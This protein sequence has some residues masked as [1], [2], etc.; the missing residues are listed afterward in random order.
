MSKLDDNLSPL[1]DEYGEVKAELVKLEKRKKEIVAFL[2]D[3]GIHELEG[4]LFRVVVSQVPESTGPDWKTI[5]AKLKPSRQLVRA[6]Q[7][8]TR[9]GH[10]RVSVY[11]R[12]GEVT[13]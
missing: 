1:A 9:K 3:A 7:I 11:G 5:A 13:A 2:E 10:T 4:D 6:H 12:T 8:T